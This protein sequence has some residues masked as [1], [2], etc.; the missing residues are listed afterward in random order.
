MTEMS[1]LIAPRYP[2]TL[3]V[4][5][6]LLL[7]AALGW[8]GWYGMQLFLAD[9]D[10]II[11]QARDLNALEVQNSKLDNRVADLADV[12]R[13]NA[14]EV[15]VFE[16][17]LDELSQAVA[18]LSEQYQGGRTRMQMTVV[19]HLLM[20]ANERA[21]LQHDVDGAMTALDLADQRLGVLGEPRLF[22]VRRTI[23]DEIA[24]LREV[25]R[26]DLTAAALTF[27]SL[28]S[29]VPRLPLRAQ[30]PQHFEIK[31][32]PVPVPAAAADWPERLWASVKQ[33][34][35][36]LF[37]VHRN[38]GPAP[39][40]LSPDDQALVYQVLLLKLEGA[41]LA[42]LGGDAVSYRDLCAAS[43]AWITDYFRADDPGVLAA[44]AEL[45]R[46]GSLKLNPAIPDIT[47]SLTLLR[48]QMEGPAR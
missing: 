24:A 5:L 8:G 45:E 2:R 25:P 35:G 21:L 7:L 27:S 6:M 36:S 46:L 41:R 33:A 12:T 39:R 28:I 22:P 19:E 13:R 34:L 43:A 30:V 31:A 15:T 20:T 14:G 10:Q 29:R 11:T 3:R 17:R 18:R 48:S 26:A 32:P 40:L 23:A 42:M 37:S 44:Q 1:T 47:R 9:H 16:S 38:S 4:M